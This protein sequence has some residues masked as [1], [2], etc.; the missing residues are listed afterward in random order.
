MKRTKYL[1]IGNSAGGIGAVEAIR[2]ADKSG[3][4]TV[5]SDETYP[6]YSRPLISE[7]LFENRPIEKML[8]RAPDFYEKNNIQAILGTKVEKIDAKAN[9]ANL[10]DGTMIL[11]EKLLLATG[12][13]PIIPQMDGIKANGVFTFTTLND[14]TAIDQYLP[15]VKNVVVIGGGLIGVSV[16]DALVKRNVNV[17]I[18]EMKDRILNTLLDEEAGTLVLSKL[19]EKDVRVITGRTVTD[20]NSDFTTEIVNGVRLDNGREIPAEM[21]IIAVGVKPRVELTIGTGIKVNRGILVDRMMQTS[22]PHIY[23]CGDAAEAFDFVYGNNRVTPIWPNA[24]VGGSVAGFNMAGEK[25]EY[26]GGT[27]M[28]SIKYFGLSVTSAGMVSPPDE[29]YEVISY[30]NGANYKKII[31][32]DGF[33]TGLILAG[34][35]ETS[36]IIFGLMKDRVNINECKQA[37]LADD[38]SFLSLPEAIWRK[39]L[40]NS[41][42]KPVAE[43]IGGGVR[44]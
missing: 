5:V 7:H 3:V 1:I 30:K 38:F 9:T 23:A 24:Y 34:N 8:F 43:A 31:L 36:G 44:Q 37:I 42:I 16:T 22:V 25:T 33:V 28:N 32:K 11:W 10:D 20:I 21:V 15:K 6:A 4:I 35:I 19:V 14:A 26:L 2:R 40:E 29:T 18:V 41:F 12:G 17:T 27:A 39:R 13:Q